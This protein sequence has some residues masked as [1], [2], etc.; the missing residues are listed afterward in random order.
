LE[1]GEMKLTFFELEAWQKKYLK[2]KLK[3]HQ[4]K[5]VDDELTIK[6]AVKAKDAE[7]IG[8]FIY[9]EV[10]KEVLDK[11]PKL[12]FVVTMSTGFDHIDVKEC[13]KRKIRVSNVPY[14]GEN[15]VAE[16]AIGLMIALG[17]NLPQAVARTRKGNF[18]LEGLEGIDMKGKVLGVVG[19]GNIGQHV[20]QIAKAMEMEVVVVNRSRDNELA[21]KLGFRY[22]SLNSLLKKSDIISLH[23]PLTSKTR[24]LISMKN[25]RSIKKGAYIINT[26]RGGLIQTKALIYGLDKRIIHGAALDVLEGEDE[27]KEERLHKKLTR[28]EK[29]VLRQ[30]HLL[31]KD[32]DVL[33]TPHSAF[34]TREALVRIL[35]RTVEN[36]L[37]KGKKN[38]V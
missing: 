6:N 23:L 9:S 22:V 19:S 35:D 33:I 8:V 25:V 38:C 27:L 32:K 28:A 36:V 16:H 21:K 4:V 29:R 14:Y 2:E 3:K 26:A 24:H 17:K 18:D 11:L 34:Y 20:I 30:N 31:L 7:G 12:K 5:F 10:T 1:E 13:K 15:T 37:C